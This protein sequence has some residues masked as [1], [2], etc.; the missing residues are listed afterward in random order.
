M[1]WDR[2][3][4]MERIAALHETQEILR[5]HHSLKAGPDA[6]PTESFPIPEWGGANV[7]T[8]RATTTRLTIYEV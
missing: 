4:R 8:S 5:R 3:S 2:Q 6:H 1:F 7:F